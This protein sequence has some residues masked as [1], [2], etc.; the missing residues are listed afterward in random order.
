MATLTKEIERLNVV[1]KGKVDEAA[2]L[3]RV[4]AEITEESRQVKIRLE[5]S[6]TWEIRFKEVQ[7]ERDGLMRNAQ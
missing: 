5:Q 7:I 6:S 3:H 1:L 2:G 4:V